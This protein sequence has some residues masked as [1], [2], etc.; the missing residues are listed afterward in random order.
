MMITGLTL[1][2]LIVP[3]LFSLFVV[4]ALT[5]RV[6]AAE[7]T[8]ARTAPGAKPAPGVDART[9][10]AR[11][12]ALL[13]NG[14]VNGALLNLKQATVID[15]KNADIIADYAVA[16]LYS[17]QDEDAREQLS[18][19][20]RLR[21]DVPWLWELLGQCCLSLGRS[22]EAVNAFKQ[23]LARNPQSPSAVEWRK[24]ISIGE[25]EIL[26][27]KTD[28]SALGITDYLHLTTRNGAA[29]W[30]GQSMP[31]QVYIKP[32]ATG[33]NHV[34]FIFY[35]KQAFEEWSKSSNGLVKFALTEDPAQAQILCSW[36]DSL[37]VDAQANEGGETRLHFA[38]KVLK[39]VDITF[40]TKNSRGWPVSDIYFKK[41]ALHQIGHALGLKEHSYEANDIMFFRTRNTMSGLSERDKRTLI[42][43]YS[44]DRQHIGHQPAQPAA[45]ARPG[46]GNMQPMAAGLTASPP[47]NSTGQPTQ[48]R[49][50]PA[51]FSPEWAAARDAVQSSSLTSLPANG[52]SQNISS[53]GALG[54]RAVAVLLPA[55]KPNPAFTNNTP[56][57]GQPTRTGTGTETNSPDGLIRIGSPAVSRSLGQPTNATYGLPLNNRGSA[58]SAAN[59]QHCG[60]SNS[61]QRAPENLVATAVI[62]EN[63]SSAKTAQPAVQRTAP[64]ARP[65]LQEG[66]QLE[67]QPAMSP[68][69]T[70]NSAPGA[71][72]PNT[73]SIGSAATAS[74]RPSD[75]R[76][77]G[78][79]SP[80]IKTSLPISSATGSRPTECQPRPIA[81]KPTDLP[82]AFGSTTSPAPKIASTTAIPLA[83]ASPVSQPDVQRALQ[84]DPILDEANTAMDDMD[85]ARAIG[86]L[87]LATKS[88][89]EAR[90]HLVRG[91]IR[92]ANFYWSSGNFNQAEKYFQ[93]ALTSAGGQ[94]SLLDEVTSEYNKFRPAYATS[95][96]EQ[97]F[98]LMQQDRFDLAIDKL[99]QSVALQAD[100]PETL[101]NYGV[102][103][104]H[105]GQI[106]QGIAQFKKA[107]SL[108]PSYSMAWGQ[109]GTCYA[110]LGK[111]KD[112]VGAFKKNLELDPA[113]PM[114]SVA[115]QEIARLQ[116]SCL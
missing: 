68:P 59:Q 104:M 55:S 31:L 112:A 18:K 93:K 14:D 70:K 24:L 90:P 29:R 36:S 19:A 46:A 9:I 63:L 80:S 74:A 92:A 10:A 78:T 71:I 87:E 94:Q 116:R 52:T 64:A 40:L 35:L 21:P 51:P 102:S 22:E 15:P 13:K 3:A 67:A 75:V 91:C 16:L 5:P 49:R 7:T 34:N 89:S 81:A 53:E 1:R 42:G 113:G 44:I 99:K 27:K 72:A 97:G 114:A 77:N 101:C 79:P 100:A 54:E 109:L 88:H 4:V 83:V 106:E 86:T 69:A 33:A 82:K 107:V 48:A 103:L 95:L 45:E 61:S 66:R 110:K 25:K 85:F 115:K 105:E 60:S 37:P 98:K 47:A 8:R 17:G 76:R 20:V 84:S 26:D 28:P 65:G 12:N 56:A 6:V 38:D 41:V 57:A 39:S 96:S 62:P 11:G 73:A 2:S 23:A 43:L 32:L 108:R 50:S 58:V 111:S 30:S